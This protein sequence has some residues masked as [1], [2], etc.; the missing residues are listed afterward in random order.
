M[1]LIENWHGLGYIMI[2]QCYE[3][4]NESSVRRREIS[5]LMDNKFFP[6]IRIIHRVPTEVVCNSRNPWHDLFAKKTDLSIE[7]INQELG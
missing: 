2:I 3:Y 5:S 1:V 4:T 6:L 7:V